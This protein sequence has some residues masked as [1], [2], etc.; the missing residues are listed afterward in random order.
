MEWGDGWDDA[1]GHVQSRRV[2]FREYLSRASVWSQAYPQSAAA[3]PFFDITAYAAPE[4][5]LSHTTEAELKAL[6]ARLP[7][8]EVRATCAGAVRL[9][10]LRTQDPAALPDLPDLYEP[11]ILFYERG[12]EFLRESSGA[13]DLTGVSLPLGARSDYLGN[14]PVTQLST[15]VLDALDADG[16][17]T[18]YTAEDGQGPLLRRRTLRG[19]QH[20]ELFGRTLRWE[21]TER[22]E[23]ALSELDELRAAGLI[24]AMVTAAAD[25]AEGT[26]FSIQ[27]GHPAV[28]TRASAAAADMAD[29]VG[30]LYSSETD[31]AVIVWNRVPVRLSYAHDIAALLDDLVPLL[32]EV[33]RADFAQAEVFW[34][35]DT[36]SAEWTLAREDESL[37]IRS[38]WHSTLGNYESL[39]AE[40]G[41]AVVRPEAFVGE[42]AKILRRIVAD[43]EAKGVRMEDDDLYR[44]TKNLLACCPAAWPQP[45]PPTP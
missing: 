21:P 15:T 2:I 20:D 28:R 14:P 3:W 25:P 23:A 6:L 37:R 9:A 43:V 12:G 44:R 19:A 24:G 39:L 29:A 45:A 34:G 36:F 35:S 27:A 32:E 30:E 26:G 1:F 31:D 40:C 22:V 10:E 8:G 11:L 16:R 38:R 41:D 17:I 13:L 5:R 33:Q 4:F 18:Y 7:S 42:W